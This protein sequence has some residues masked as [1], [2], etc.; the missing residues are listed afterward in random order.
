LEHPSISIRLNTSFDESAK[1][2]GWDH[3]FYSGPID[4]YYQFRYG[5]LRYRT[6]SWD[7]EIVKGDYY[8]HSSV[9]YPSEDVIYTRRR[10]HKHFAYWE[11][12][13][14][15]I[16]FTEYSKET[17]PGDEPYYPLGLEADRLLFWQYFKE[18]EKETSMSFIGRLATYRYLD[19][20][21]VIG[22]S[23]ELAEG[24]NGFP[25]FHPNVKVRMDAHRV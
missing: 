5:R 25:V 20:H 10:E 1:T 11:N 8:G 12:H 13:E 19:M 18:A 2:E 17:L 16:I 15:S 6:V 3:I 21:Q 24:S 7:K 14:K 23:L 4:E 22:E 9:N